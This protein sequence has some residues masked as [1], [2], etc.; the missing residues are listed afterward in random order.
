MDVSSW[1]RDLGLENYA[2]AFRANDIEFE[3]LSRLTAEDLIALGVTSVG[4]RRKLLDAIALLKNDTAGAAAEPIATA[5]RPVEAE[6]RQLTVLLCDLVGSTALAARL[7]PE[8]LRAVMQAYQ[9]VCAEV[10]SRFEGHVAKYM[11]DGVLA[12][13]GWPVAHEDDAERAVRAG[14]A[15]IESIERL[16]SHADMQLRA[17]AGIATGIVVVG[18]LIGEGA[19]REEAV[20]GEVPNLSARLQALAEPGH[21][22]ISQA[23]RRLVGGLFEL[24]D[25][26]P[27]R[28]KGFAEPIMAWRVAGES[29]AE[30]RFEARQT[31]G[32]TPLVG[33]EQEVA[34]LLDRWGQARDGE[35]QVVLL[36]GEPGIGK[37]RLVRE[38]LGR[39]SDEPHIRLLYQCS[40]HHT[41]SPLHPLIEQLERAT[42][43]ARDD[44]PATRLN[45]LEA[46]L[47]R[48]IERLDEVVPLIAGL[49]GVPTVERYPALTLTPEVQKR[50]TLQALVEHL[51]GLAALQPVLALYEDV[52]WIDPSMLELLGLVIER[53][54]R[55][56][57]LV[58]ITFRPEF[59]PPRTGH[60]H[61]TTLTM[62]RLGRRQGADLVARVM[63]DKPLPAEIVE[64]IVARTDG[65]PLFVEELTKTVLELGLL[66]DAG[67]HY[68]LSGPL[69]PLAIPTTLHNSLM[70]RLDRLAPV[71]EVAQ[72]GAVI[73]R[74]FS[75][76]LLAAV[77]PMSANQLGDALEQLVSSELVFR[78]GAPPEA[79]YTFKHALVQDAAYQSILKS[80]RQQLHARIAEALEQEFPDIGQT[81]PEVLAQHF[82]E[83]G[84]A[85]RSISYWRSAGE[86]AARRCA[87]VEAIAHLSR[88]LD[89]IGS[90]QNAAEHLDEEFALRLAIG[91]PLIATQGHAAPE[92]ERNYSRAWTLCDQLGRSAELFPVLRGLW[93]Y[94]L[95]RGELQRAHDL[96]ARLVTL[97]EEQGHQSAAPW[98][99]ALE[100]QRWSSLAG[101]PMRRQR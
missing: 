48:G 66:A 74:E 18:D 47:A 31:A 25:L 37:S 39:L 30:G 79:T 68:E 20:V 96:S 76:E 81:Q 33:R 5:L 82:T 27:Q 57:V 21:L 44:P 70:A 58:L 84:L 100:A 49:L 32:L 87:D 29:R 23:T 7:D 63:G 36:A 3:L 43:F 85:A 69:P 14:L 28:L 73:G 89:L 12:Y 35:G 55:L 98:P 60:A 50:R 45:K 67:D 6:R 94:H 64:Q 54:G 90:L 65:V 78:C 71:K 83:A 4:H 95:V 34:L 41:T 53:I 26:G 62:S 51:A 52:H 1:L 92:V 46:Y 61:V 15:M 97:A 40:P 38:M 80:R 16:D 17:R 56:P 9:A 42:G 2:P 24:A 99:G 22:V 72:T 59:Q 75:H 86:L 91:G 19:S 101:S 77:A 11:G 8:D 88:C 93:N 13:F 10:V